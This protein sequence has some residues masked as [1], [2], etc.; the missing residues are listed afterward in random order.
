MRRTGREALAG[1]AS[2]CS[3]VYFVTIKQDIGLGSILIL[4]ELHPLCKQSHQRQCQD[5]LHCNY[6]SPPQF[7]RAPLAAV[8]DI[9]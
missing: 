1:M 3:R 4:E 9:F 8:M 5:M 7:Q 6:I 2:V